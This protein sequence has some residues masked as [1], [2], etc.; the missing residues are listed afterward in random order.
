[1]SYSRVEETMTAAWMLGTASLFATTFGAL[2]I[3]LYLYK[4]PS[5]AAEWQTPDGS[6][7]YLR[8][9]KMLL[10]GMGLLSAW[11]VVQDLAVILL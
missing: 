8:H 1:M 9:R 3:F 10:A 7:A 5:S 11:L 4:L 2:L 6:R